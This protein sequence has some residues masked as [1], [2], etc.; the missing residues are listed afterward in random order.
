MRRVA[1]GVVAVVVIGVVLYAVWST[2]AAG[3]LP[4][5]IT[6]PQQIEGSNIEAPV[7]ADR[8][9]VAEAVIV[10]IQHAAL[11][12][13]V[14]GI[15]DEVLAFEGDQ[16]EAGQVLA[17]LRSDREVIAVAQAQSAVDQ[18]RAQVEKLANGARPE[19]IDAAQAAVDAALANLAILQQGAS[20][21]DIQA[22][23]A[24][25]A[26]AQAGYARVAEGAD[27]QALIAAQ[28]DMAN[29][30]AAVTRAQRAYDQVKWRADIGTLPESA[31]LQQATNEL[32]AAQARYADLQSG[33]EASQYA[34]AAALIDQA[35]A[36]LAG[37]QAPPTENEI[38]A[39]EAQ[40]RQAEAERD[41]IIAGARPEDIAAASAELAAAETELMQAQLA[42]NEKQL[43][44]PFAGELAAMDLKVG[45][46]I[47]A[48]LPV[49]QL[50]DT[51]RWLVETTD[52][53]ELNV[54]D[55]QVADRV[56]VSVDAL[57]DAM[58]VGSVQSIKPLG[59]NILGDITYKV[60]VALEDSDPR[61]R[62]NMT[63]AATI[64]P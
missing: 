56:S 2:Q 23:Q 47:A 13:E 10:P 19:E 36:Q 51:S 17:R 49:A 37:V 42:L 35:Q 44:A 8:S 27:D 50:A 61:L 30:E 31:A 38:A 14:S 57:P 11:S 12:L 21:E 59:E 18:A 55:V 64:E 9:I 58:L 63:A 39:A 33:A 48:G 4:E 20:P 16:V 5:L 25:V 46:Q 6:R 26:S 52:L 34:E 22:A 15:V 45:Q 7:L 1:I 53:T 62:W 3:R 29:A 41:L 54:V 40:V 43:R 32:A 24:V 28:A 60:T